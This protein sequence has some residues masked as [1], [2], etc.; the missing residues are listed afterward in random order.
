MIKTVSLLLMLITNVAM[1]TPTPDSYSAA[2]GQGIYGGRFGSGI[3]GAPTLTFTNAAG[4]DP[5]MAGIVF[6]R[7]AVTGDIKA[8]DP[9]LYV[10]I[11]RTWNDGSI[12]HA[13]VSGVATADQEVTFTRGAHTGTA[14]THA[15]IQAAGPTAVVDLGVY[16]SVSL[17][18]LIVSAPHR[19]WISTP[20]MV[21]SHY[22]ADVAGTSLMVWFHVRHWSDGSTWVRSVVE[23]PVMI[24]TDALDYTYDATVTIDGVQAESLTGHVHY[25]NTAWTADRWI[26]ATQHDVVVRHDTAQIQATDLTPPYG[27]ASAIDE[28]A[29]DVLPVSHTVGGTLLYTTSM[30]AGG[31]QKQIGLLPN[32]EAQYLVSG[33]DRA[34]RSVRAHVNAIL[35][36]P[37]I[38]RN[39]DHEILKPTDN[40]LGNYGSTGA[41]GGTG[42]L[43]PAE[44]NWETAHHPSVG[45]LCYLLTGDHLALDAM[46]GQCATLYQQLSTSTGSSVNRISR[47]QTR[48]TAWFIRTVGQAAAI[49]PD[50]HINK[51]DLQAWLDG[52]AQYARDRSTDDPTAVDSQLGYPWTWSTYNPNA[53][54]KVAPWMHNFWIAAMGHVSDLEPLADMTDF[55]RLR[56]WMY[57]GTVGILGDDAGYCFTLAG[58]YT[59]GVSDEIVPNFGQRDASQLYQSWDDVWLAT[60][61][62]TP[63]GC[64]NTLGGT[65]GS[66]PSSAP[67]G[68]WG[69]LLPAIQYAVKHN[70]PGAAVA[71]DRLAAADNYADIAN[72]GWSSTP[73]WGVKF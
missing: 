19:T 24:R 42:N 60:H 33:D 5:V 50:D 18:D 1:A 9:G 17:A 10:T 3:Q 72:A 32:W 71:W 40:P 45:Y 69:N 35:T 26:G 21:E 7:G 63:P 37:V 27:M 4:Q 30:G 8:S 64:D 44:A 56:D 38:W 46:T 13:V 43:G 2:T 14:L 58:N 62:P 16:G 73:V 49:V 67:T 23:N 70:A 22:R 39:A 61:G 6:P 57:R 20:G 41:H 55:N 47:S 54:L 65:S 12:K 25:R 66:N 34:W 51:Q 52:N 31:F 11:K 48:G 28:A 29:L 59:L 53:P 15:D 36:Y 68:Y